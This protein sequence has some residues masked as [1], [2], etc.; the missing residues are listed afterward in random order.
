[1]KILSVNQIILAIQTIKW[2]FNRKKFELNKHL[3]IKNRIL[4]NFKLRRAVI[5]LDF[6]YFTQILLLF[7]MFHLNIRLH[8]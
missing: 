8:S 7:Q 6:F 3:I 2:C 5:I 4:N 1:M